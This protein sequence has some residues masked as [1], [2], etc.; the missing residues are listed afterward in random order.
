VTEGLHHVAL[1]VPPDRIQDCVRFWELLGFEQA[2]APQELAD[3]GVLWLN[4]AGTSV[5]LMSV[6]E[7]VIPAR[8]HAAVVLDSYAE[9]IGR[10]RAAGF[11][12]QPRTRHWGA[13]RAYVRDPA[14][15]LVEVMAAPPGPGPPA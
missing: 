8:G 15:H 1:E 12:P 14:G 2:E 5:H 11:D 13:A 3:R 6:G 10:L 7:P 9:T 4:S